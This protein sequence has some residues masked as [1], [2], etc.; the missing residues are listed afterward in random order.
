[1]V[2]ITVQSFIDQIQ[3]KNYVTEMLVTTKEELMG[4][5]APIIIQNFTQRFSDLILEN[6]LVRL[7]LLVEDVASVTKIVLESGIINLPFANTKVVDSFFPNLEAG[8]PLLLN[9]IVESKDLNPS[10]LHIKTMGAVN[11]ILPSTEALLA[12]L[13]TKIKIAI[14]TILTNEQLKTEQPAL[15]AD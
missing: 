13:Q 1:M 4:E 11:E 12:E 7:E 8:V 14:T 6:N 3:N 2:N 5:Q 9:L 10:G 15:T